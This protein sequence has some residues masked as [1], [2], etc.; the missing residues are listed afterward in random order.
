MYTRL[1]VIVVFLVIGPESSR[2]QV[3]S[4][5]I[6]LQAGWN[7]VWLNL[8]PEPSALDLI[9]AGQS[10]PLD[11][12]A[13]W[14]LEGVSAAAAINSG[15][16]IG[17]WFFHDRDVPAALSTLRDL[18]GHR[19]YLIHMHSAGQLQISG[20]PLVR[21]V[22]FGSH[23]S[24]LF[25][26][27]S[28]VASGILTFQ[29]FFAHPT[30]NGKLR[31]SGAPL[32]PDIF[33]L[34]AGD[35]VRKNLVDAIDPNAAYWVNVVQ[36]FE[37]AGLL[38]VT[39]SPNGL[40]FGRTT[41]QRTLSIEVPSSTI[42]RSLFLQARDCAVLSENGTCAGSGEVVDWLE[43]RDSTAPGLPIWLPLS[44]GV[45]VAV[46]AGATRVDVELRARRSELGA[47]A[48]N[49][50]GGVVIEDF[51]L[52]IDVTDDT[53]ARAVLS[54]SVSIE[55]VF[56]TWIGRATLTQVSV[57]P[58]L[59]V[60]PLDQSTAPPLGMTLLL[61]LPD[62]TGGGSP[63]LLDRLAVSVFRDGRPLTR[64]FNSVLF[65]RS[66]A[67]VGDPGDPLDPLG[68]TGTLQGTLHISPEDPLNPY[69]HR[70]HPEHRSGYDITRAITINLQAVAPSATDAL[71]GLDGTFGPGK[72]TGVYREVITG[73][74][75]D[76]ITIQGT[77]ELERLSVAP[78]AAAAR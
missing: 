32:K 26:A 33:A 6:D 4:E 23:S 43:Y 31:S 24:N 46:P 36:N 19:G 42:P 68:A 71:S 30:S 22:S 44:A 50:G 20:R 3:V 45:T 2:A 17:R 38:D 57:H 9:L 55:P 73:I 70:Y 59:Q 65:D 25:G 34:S 52:V 10:P 11:Y 61:D 51:P 16:P 67:L 53:G 56:G 15:E 29:E 27:L 5:S 7:A 63:Q 35:Y 60:L 66:V 18:H 75:L 40:A 76:P 28:N 54:A 41:A 72:L 8:E 47:A 62:P 14:T 13:F 58:S 1:A 49:R 64:V 69:R 74:A 78:G 12:Q 77:F 37:Y 39:S 21:S 48:R